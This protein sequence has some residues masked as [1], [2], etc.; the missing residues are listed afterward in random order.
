MLQEA[1]ALK[2]RGVDI[3]IAAVDTHGRPE[4]AELLPGL[5]Q[6]PLKKFEYRGVTVEEMDFDGVLARAPTIAIVDEVAHTNAPGSKN[7]KRYRDI[8]E[9][10][11]A[12][13][14]VVCAFNIQHLESLNDVI[15]RA[16]HVRVRETV[17]DTFLERADQIVNV[18]LPV[19]EL[20]ER[21]KIG[22][23]YADEKIPVA[24]EGFFKDENLLALRELTFREIVD[25][26]ERIA[27]PKTG[28]IAKTTGPNRVMVCIS[29]MP[30]RSAALL[31]HGSR[32]AGR[33][34]TKW[35]VVYVQTPA[36][37][38]DRI[39]SEAQRHLLD[40]FQRAQ[41]LGAEVVRL[42]DRDPVQSVLDFAR[43]HGVGYVLIGRSR[44]N[45]LYRLLG[46]DPM[47]RMVDMA[48]GLDLDIVSL[49]HGENP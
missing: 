35:Y 8:L 4:T 30:E 19:E 44:R 48:D 1:H 25:S 36:E 2:K 42:H 38:P 31:R 7:T 6:V 46:R 29:S 41:E 43:S 5:E 22:K 17:P 11:S 34:N 27:S 32:M 40:N 15:E 28:E 12:G 16:T 3:A 21:L 18:D 47:H 20:I 39:P 23:I 37:A 26:L 24:L 45:W 49:E 9:L 13:I 10:L 33:L 14:N